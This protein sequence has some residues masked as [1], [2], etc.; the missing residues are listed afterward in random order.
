[1]FESNTKEI[2]SSLF[3]GKRNNYSRGHIGDY[4]TAYDE[5]FPIRGSWLVSSD[6]LGTIRLKKWLYRLTP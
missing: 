3:K 2:K 4:D 6:F 5:T 1:M